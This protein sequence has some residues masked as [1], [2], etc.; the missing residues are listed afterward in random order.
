MAHNPGVYQQLVGD[1]RDVDERPTAAA[2]HPDPTD[3]VYRY[4]PR[5]RRDVTYAWVYAAVA[6]V[7]F[8]LGC[9]ASTHAESSYEKLADPNM[10]KLA[11]HCD[12]GRAPEAFDAY[13]RSLAEDEEV[14]GAVFLRHAATWLVLSTLGAVAVGLGFLA[15]FR[16]HAQRTV[17]AMVYFKVAS[18][19]TLALVVG[20]VYFY[21]AY[22]YSHHIGNLTDCVLYLPY[23]RSSGSDGSNG[24]GIFLALLGALS[25]FVFWLWRRE[26]DLVA[27][28]LTV[29]SKSLQ[30][31]PHV[32]TAVVGV[33]MTLLVFM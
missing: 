4:G 6:S 33:K 5:E 13:R 31:N 30:D 8:I 14:D 23:D 9:V 20:Y 17:W 25:A 21:L 10:L 16:T 29:A 1:E 12:A 3:G 32:V 11:S 22:F 18:I 28:L 26:I 24:G 15:M 7:V 2:F 19:F 27:K